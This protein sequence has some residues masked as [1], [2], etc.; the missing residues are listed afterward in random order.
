MPKTTLKSLMEKVANAQVYDNG[1][2]FSL[3]CPEGK[4]EDFAFFSPTK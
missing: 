1:D 3:G 2:L 4:E